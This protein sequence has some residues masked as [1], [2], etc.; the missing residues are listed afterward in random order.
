MAFEPV[1]LCQIVIPGEAAG[2]KTSPTVAFPG[3]YSLNL[4][5]SNGDR[6]NGLASLFDHLA[7]LALKQPAKAAAVAR[8][9]ASRV[10]PIVAP[11]ASHR[12][13]HKRALQIAQ[14]VR[15]PRPLLPT[16]H[17]GRI[18]TVVYMAKGQTGDLINFEQAT[19]DLLQDADL[20]GNDHWINSHDGSE[21]RWTEPDSPRVEIDLFDIGPRTNANRP[22]VRVLGL[23]AAKAMPPGPLR[24][25]VDDP[26]SGRSLGNCVAPRTSSRDALV[27]EAARLW[28]LAYHRGLP[29][30][31]IV[32]C[33]TG[34]KEIVI[35]EPILVRAG[36]RAPSSDD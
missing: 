17:L 27:A 2:K 8:A 21:R 3:L 25:V 7:D 24:F 12:A 20:I 15:G 23:S 10:K 28:R 29:D 11:P 22:S 4:Y 9:C 1:H 18:R 16:G 14:C 32:R 34:Q 13:W 30:G 6:V 19:W 33:K 5:R 26:S 35:G 31:A 36:E